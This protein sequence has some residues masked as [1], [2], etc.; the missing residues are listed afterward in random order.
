M[1]S[2]PKAPNA[3]TKLSIMSGGKTVIS[4]NH[5]ALLEDCF[6]ISDSELE[7]LNNPDFAVSGEDEDEEDEGKMVVKSEFWAILARREETSFWIR[8]K[9]S[10]YGK[11]ESQLLRQINRSFQDQSNIPSKNASVC[12]IRLSFIPRNTAQQ[13]RRDTLETST[14]KS[15]LL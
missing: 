13:W 5:Q 1:L 15:P 7:S 12:C 4:S 9:E 14:V 10:A 2:V 6:L 8:P 11:N 3:L